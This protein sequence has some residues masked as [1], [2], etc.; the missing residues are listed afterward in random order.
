[1]KFPRETEINFLRAE[2]S[3]VGYRDQRYFGQ[4]EQIG[5]VR[6]SFEW[7]QIPLNL[8][9]DA[10]SLYTHTGNGVLSVDD[11]IQQALQAGTTT[12]ANVFTQQLRPFDLRSQRDLATA[13]MEVEARTMEL[14]VLRTK[15]TEAESDVVRAR[16][17]AEH[18]GH[19][20]RHRID[21]GEPWLEDGDATVA[22]LLDPATEGPAG[23]G[24][25]TAASPGSRTSTSSAT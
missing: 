3:N 16:A 1:M 2:A 20:P 4:F 19:E 25:K 14:E 7:N 24:T 8:S 17:E 10:Q 9:R 5:R 18:A 22:V 6:A 21:D 13:R 15:L 12:I 23:S 11:S